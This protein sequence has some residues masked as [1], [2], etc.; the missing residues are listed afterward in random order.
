MP[1]LASSI[2]T[3]LKVVAGT[4][5]VGIGTVKVDAQ[6]NSTTVGTALVF[7]T[8]GVPLLSEVHMWIQ[9]PHAYDDKKV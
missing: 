9:A 7:E 4:E 5:L 8:G 1:F 6:H 3:D 2:A